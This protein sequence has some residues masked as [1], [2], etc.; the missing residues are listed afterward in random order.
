MD[1]H[2]SNTE[3]LDLAYKKPQ[4]KLTERV[5]G[6]SLVWGCLLFSNFKTIKI[7]K[8][9]ATILHM[10]STINAD[11]YNITAEVFKGFRI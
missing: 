5:G 1:T 11:I 3:D 10:E 6:G 2:K 9:Q 7:N 4:T 8:N